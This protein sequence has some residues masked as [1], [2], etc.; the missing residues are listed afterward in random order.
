MTGFDVMGA[1]LI[2]MML[3]WQVPKLFAAVLG[4][5]PALSGGDLVSAGTTVV[6][7]A[8]TVA[9]LGAGAIAA[10]AGGT[11]ALSG[12]AGASSSVGG[13]MGAA[14][15]AGGGSVPPP[16]SPSPGPSSGG[17]PR[18]PNPPSNGSA[19]APV[20]ST[21]QASMPNS[22]GSVHLSSNGSANFG[23]TRSTSVQESSPQRSALASVGDLAC[24]G[25]EGE[26]PAAGFVAHSVSVPTRSAGSAPAPPAS[27]PSN[28]EN[29]PPTET[30][31][32][33]DSAV[34]VGPSA[35]SDVQFVSS[36]ANTKHGAEGPPVGER[37]ASR[38]RRTQK[39]FSGAADRL[40]GTRQQFGGLPSDAAP[41]TQPPRMPIDHSE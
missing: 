39:V 21:S 11:A 35:A 30:V 15:S 40:R 25:F 4:G 38:A 5:S 28:P 33:S 31:G 8:A 17:R 13:G 2:F 9:S 7:G 27:P 16:P 20:P 10:A 1:A 18:Q 6:A 12:G 23:T 36:S 19:T 24:S 29:P 41:H 26:R 14:G 34:G 3:C 22:A 32:G 37:V